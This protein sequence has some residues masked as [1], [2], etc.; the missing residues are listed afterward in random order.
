VPRVIVKLKWL[1]FGVHHAASN[2]C[3]PEGQCGAEEA[4]NQNCDLHRIY[5]KVKPWE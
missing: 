3:L 5:L 2:R 1:G 4:K